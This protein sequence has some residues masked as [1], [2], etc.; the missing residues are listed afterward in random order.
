[1]HRLMVTSN[2]YRMASTPDTADLTVDH[3]NKY[4]WRMLP[5]RMEAEA[6]RDSILYVSGQLDGSMGGPDIDF[7]R[8]STTLRRSLYFRHA[9]E[10]QMEFLKIFDGPEVIECYQR[11]ESIMPQQ[12]LALANSD[13]TWR[14]ARLL[15]RSLAHRVEKANPARF[16]TAA[17][18]QVLSRSPTAAELAEC[19]AFLQI[20]SQTKL[21]KPTAGGAVD[22][23]VPADDQ[24]LRVRENLVHALMN[25]HDF[26]TI[27]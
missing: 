12:A 27:R 10:K 5:R 21:A 26:V 15:A 18:E 23:R 14:Q 3:D 16:A 7:S 11:K 13:L 20:G 19:V 24:S 8:G 17:F 22:P 9:S 25:H 6:V 1:M 4:L 2:A